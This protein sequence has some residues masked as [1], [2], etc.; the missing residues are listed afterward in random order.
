MSFEVRFEGSVRI[1][2]SEIKRKRIPKR[3]AGMAET[4]RGES[5]V[6]TRLG[7]EIERGRAELTRWSV[8]M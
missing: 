1:N 5:N 6:D 2:R 4:T 7:K 8:R 3:G